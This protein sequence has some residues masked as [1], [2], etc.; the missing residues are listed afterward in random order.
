[1]EDATANHNITVAAIDLGSNTFRLLIVSITEAG[2]VVLCKSNGPAGLA[3][4]LTATG[5]LSPEIITGALGVLAEFKTE[6]DQYNID[7]CRC[8]GTETLRQA[9]NA[10]EFLALAADVIGM[11]IEVVS[12]SAEA[13][14]SSRGVL[15]AIDSAQITSP[16]LIID[17]GGSSTE[18]IYL[19][20]PDA[21]PL[22]LSLAAGAVAF[23]KLAATG[24]LGVAGRNFS[25]GLKGFFQNHAIVA[26]QV[27]A[28]ATGGTATALAVLDLGLEHYDA[29]KVQGHQ[30]TSGALQRISAELT[31]MP[32]AARDLLPGL[33]KGRGN[34]LLAG[35]EIYQEILATIAV[36]GMIISDSGLLEGIM[37]GC[38]EQDLVYSP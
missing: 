17:V 25:A 14:L 35:L 26:G 22:S 20:E 21:V 3:R 30:L 38:L 7:C 24:D 27:S 33:E 32:V 2:P 34:I 16:L 15:A 28:V 6:L 5:D 13:R 29:K 8:C 23:T 11:N 10:G 37:L 12:G 19:Q 18:L 1:M 9:G 36:D 4:G 31:A